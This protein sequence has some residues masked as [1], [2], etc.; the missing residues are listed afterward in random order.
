MFDATYV[1]SMER[2]GDRI[3]AFQKRY[4]SLVGLTAQ[5]HDCAIFPGIDAKLV[6]PPTWWDQTPG[7]WGCL[8]AHMNIIENCLN[9]GIESCLIFE[10]DAVF[11]PDFVERFPK[12]MAALPDDWNMAYLG[13]C[14]RKVPQ[15]PPQVV[16]DQVVHCKSL[17]GT[18]GFGFRGTEFMRRL[19]RDLWDRLFGERRH[20]IDIML[21]HLHEHY[22]VYAPHRWLVVHPAGDSDVT[23]SGKTAD[24]L[25]F[26]DPIKL[27]TAA[28][29]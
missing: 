18:W 19:Y 23:N 17:T 9:L 20:H 14:C 3:A 10:D 29:V 27:A 7:S 22:R 21:C 1:V 12:F 4:R 2:R 26:P 25:N 15:M 28:M 5:H 16:N 8:R 24:T 6:P 13:G 11:A